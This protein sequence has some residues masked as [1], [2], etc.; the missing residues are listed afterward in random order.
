MI[1]EKG[2]DAP[3]S[4]LNATDEY[5]QNSDKLGRFLADEMEEDVNG[6]AR[7][8][9][10]YRRFVIWCGENGF[11]PE[12]A[13]NFRAMMENVAEIKK[14]RPMGS[15]RYTSPQWLVLGYRLKPAIPMP[16]QGVYGGV[17]SSA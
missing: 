5:K 10:V 14:R 16:T 15:N 1:R 3:E 9:E 12:N 6:E 4:V 8:E 13:A 11:R 7:T 2:F 17:F